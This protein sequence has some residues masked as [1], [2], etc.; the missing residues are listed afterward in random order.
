MKK[1]G[2]N[3]FGYADDHQIIKSFK[4]QSQSDVLVSQLK[5]C[6]H[7]VRRWMNSFYLKLNDD[8]TQIIVFGSRN[9]LNDL[10]INGINLNPSTTIRFVPTVKN[11]G[12]YMNHTLTFDRQL[13]ELKKKCFRTLRNIRKIKFLLQPDQVKVIVNSLVVSCLDYCNGLF[14]GATERILKQ[15]QL[16]QNS[17]SKAITGKYKHDHIGD[18]LKK[19]HWLNIRQRIVF[20]LG[21]LAYKSLNGLAPQY[22]QD[23]FRFC[24]HG[25]TLKLIVPLSLTKYGSRS[26]SV[27]GPKIFNNLPLHV[28]TSIST[29]AFKSSLKTYLFNLSDEDLEKLYH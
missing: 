16:I 21:L 11:L 13:S 14:F 18:D 9:V 24:H 12:I 19:L 6:F 15:L 26:F 7:E 22:L 1:L 3:I 10:H 27:I 2:F 29:E 25:H 17:A 4:S 8:K 23:M 5:T 20:K 28:T